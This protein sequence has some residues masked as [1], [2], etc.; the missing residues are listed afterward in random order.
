MD[1]SSV[2]ISNISDGWTQ[3]ENG[4]YSNSRQS[5]QDAMNKAMVNSA[6]D[7]IYGES[8]HGRGWA[9]LIDQNI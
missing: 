4:S 3:F 9:A 7:S 5:F 6:Y 1:Q 2:I 8:M